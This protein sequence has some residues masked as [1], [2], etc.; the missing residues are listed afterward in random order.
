[1]KTKIQIF[2]D[3]ISSFILFAIIF[4]ALFT[5]YTTR[6]YALLSAVDLAVIL[7]CVYLA[8]SEKSR[9]KAEQKENLKNFFI[10][11]PVNLTQY[12]AN[13]LSVRYKT[14]KTDG[15]LTVGDSYV[16]FALSLSPLSYANVADAFKN[17][18]RDKIV[19]FC[20]SYDKKAMRLAQNLP[21]QVKIMDENET[22]KLLSFVKALPKKRIEISKKYPLKQL[23]SD[24]ANAKLN[25]RLLFSA[26]IITL[27]SFITPFKNYYV[28]FAVFLLLLAIVPSV[29]RLAIKRKT[30]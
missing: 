2:M 1:M 23:F 22:F 12:F 26:F 20:F 5:R 19:I 28:F 27:F 25:K 10:F 17:R 15:K 21:V 11:T 13:A 4:Y 9:T 3:A 18:T 7:Q 14:D 8:H 29:I 6:L 24:L 30:R 16:H